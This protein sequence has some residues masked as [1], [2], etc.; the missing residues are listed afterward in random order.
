MCTKRINWGRFNYFYRKIES[1]N[2]GNAK[3]MRRQL[4]IIILIEDLN[5]LNALVSYVM[6]LNRL[7]EQNSKIF[8]NALNVVVKHNFD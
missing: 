8:T 1:L 7:R 2:E 3:L 5:Y 6:K 4:S